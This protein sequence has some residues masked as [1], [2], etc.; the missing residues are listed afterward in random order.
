MTEQVFSELVEGAAY[1]VEQ[2][3]GGDKSY[4]LKAMS[5]VFVTLG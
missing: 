4:K 2:P 3:V 1:G 5:F